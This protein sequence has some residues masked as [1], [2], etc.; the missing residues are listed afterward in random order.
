LSESETKRFNRLFRGGSS[1]AAIGADRLVLHTAAAAGVKAP[2]PEPG[3]VAVAPERTPEPHLR[4]STAVAT[5]RLERAKPLTAQQEHSGKLNSYQL[6]VPGHDAHLPGAAVLHSG[7]TH[8]H[9]PRHATNRQAQRH[10]H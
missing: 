7:L 1:A 8:A 3:A 9:H 4:L 2:A 10:R 5:E 6:S